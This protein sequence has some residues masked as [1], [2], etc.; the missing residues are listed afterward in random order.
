MSGMIRAPPR[1]RAWYD[2]LDAR[3]SDTVAKLAGRPHIVP[4]PHDI[5]ALRHGIL[6]TLHPPPGGDHPAFAGAA[7][8]RHRG[9]SLPADLGAAE[10][11]YP[12]HRGDRR[13]PGRGSGDHG[14]L[15]RGAVGAAAGRDLRRHRDHLHQLDRQ[16]L[17]R[18]AVRHRPRHQRRRA[19][20]AGRDQRRDHRPA[21][22]PAHPALLPQVQPGR[23]ADH[24]AGAVLR[25]ADHRA[26]LRRGRH[27]P[28]A[29]AVAGG[30]RLAGHGERRGE[31]RG[32][33]AARSGP[34]RGG[35]P[36]RAGRA[37]HDQGNQRASADRRVP[38]TRPR[39]IDRH[40]RT[41]LAGV[42]ICAAG[43]EGRQRRDPAPLRRGNRDRRCRQ[44]APGRVERQATGDPAPDHQGG[45]RQRHRDGGPHPC[46]A[47]AAH[48]MAARQHQA[49]RHLRPYH[50]DPR[51]GLRRA[52]H[53]C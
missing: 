44:L 47:A 32:A 43:A 7:A 20:R 19:R 6:R 15:R 45:R 42:G 35:R 10:R 14:Q 40:Q 8:V 31:T 12:H 26:D 11:R 50:D 1:I 52:V 30:R 5:A 22:R 2:T 13:A 28:R 34:P 18:G 4:A 17:G 49:H 37:E 41:D 29:A 33:G 21:V 38:G 53:P 16:H 24:G 9:L 39:R 36:R 23:C 46:A 27:H 3:R 25:H 51:L 48:G